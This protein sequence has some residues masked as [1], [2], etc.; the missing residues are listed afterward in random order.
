MGFK[1]LAN[2]NDALLAKQA[3][4]LLHQKN[5]LFYRVFKARFFPNCSILEA[6]YSNT[7]SYAWRSILKGRDLLLKRVRWRVGCGE[8]ISVWKDAWLPSTTQPWVS[9][10]I[11][12]GF[13]GMKVSDLID[14]A[15]NKWDQNLLHGLFIPHEVELI[16]SIP[17]CLNKVEDVVVWPFTPSGCY[18]VKSGSKFVAAKHLGSQQPSSTPND[19]GLW[20]MIWSLSVP[21]K[22][23]N[24]RWKAC[25]NALF[26]KFNLRWQHILNEDTCD[27]CKVEVEDIYHALWGCNQISQIWD[28]IPSFSFIQSKTFSSVQEV[29]TSTYEEQKNVELMASVMW[30]IWH[31]QNQV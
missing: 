9:S 13:E 12:Q 7:E 6:L 20:K 30:A 3:W 8:A 11:V 31:R 15:T 28:S 10:P 21:P 19:K 25:Q 1:D 29:I 17:L 5:L 2:F 24:F 4:R 14:P 22:V 18:T 16:T 23:H 27:S 26:V